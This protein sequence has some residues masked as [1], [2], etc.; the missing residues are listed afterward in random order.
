MSRTDAYRVFGMTLTVLS[1]FSNFWLLGFVILALVLIPFFLLQMMVYKEKMGPKMERFVPVLSRALL[2]GIV[3]LV[4]GLS[5]AE[6]MMVADLSDD[7]TAIT[8]SNDCV[9]QYTSS[10]SSRLIK[11]LGDA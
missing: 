1:L 3:F 6:S 4:Q 7:L 8:E 11:K 2:V 9:D 10:F 5:A